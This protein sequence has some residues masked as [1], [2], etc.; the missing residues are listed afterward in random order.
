MRMRAGVS[1]NC[2]TEI[3][4]EEPPPFSREAHVEHP[5]AGMWVTADGRDRDE[6]RVAERRR[7]APRR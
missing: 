2:F 1:A 4:P 3:T 5:Y 6:Q 7:G